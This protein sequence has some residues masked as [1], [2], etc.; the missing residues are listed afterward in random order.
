MSS[1]PGT[2]IV[3]PDARRGILWMLLTML[4]FVSLDSV[5]KALVQHYPVLQVVWARYFFHAVLLIALLA[6][7]LP[8]IVRTRRLGL[9]VVRAMLLVMVSLMFFAS[10]GYMKL[11]E[12]SAIMFLSPILV[13]ALSV[14]LLREKVGLRR[15][16]GVAVGFIGAL[17]II[18]PGLGVMQWAALL[19]IGAAA[20]NALYQISTRL[21]HNTDE[22]LTTLFYTAVVGALVTSAIVPFVWVMPDLTGWALMALAGLIGGV[23]HFCLIRAFTLAPAPVVAPFSY[24]SLIWSTLFGFLFFAELPDL[25]TIVG[26]LLIAGGG[27]YIFYREQRVKPP[28]Q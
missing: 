11:V 9:Q 10:L 23:S 15:W 17:I 4:L 18:R 7:R 25:W 24:S 21:L 12:A 6:P 20:A 14:P 5:A 28:G 16:A 3:Q 19:V 2:V 8:R 13:T 26:A 1:L 27:L 22:T